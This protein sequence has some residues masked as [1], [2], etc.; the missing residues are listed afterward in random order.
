VV[1][2]ESLRNKWLTASGLENMI[3]HRYAFR[4]ASN[5]TLTAM[6]KVIQLATMASDR[7]LTRCF[8]RR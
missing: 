7:I 5:F 3:K 6:N 1:E 4:D 2:G 8:S